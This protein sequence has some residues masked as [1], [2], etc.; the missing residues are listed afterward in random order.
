LRP[1]QQRRRERDVEDAEAQRAVSGAV[2]DVTD[3]RV[4]QAEGGDRRAEE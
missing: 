3:E 2:F 4:L 1:S